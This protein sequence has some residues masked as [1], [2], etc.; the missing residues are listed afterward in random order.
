MVSRGTDFHNLSWPR[1]LICFW[2]FSPG[3]ILVGISCGHVPRFHRDHAVGWGGLGESWNEKPGWDGKCSSHCSPCHL[4]DGWS[5]ALHPSF[6][7]PPLHSLFLNSCTVAVH[8]SGLE[9]EV[10]NGKSWLQLFLTLLSTKPPF[11]TIGFFIFC[12]LNTLWHCFRLHT[13]VSA[14][15]LT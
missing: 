6:P 8:S 9:F 3:D 2:Y 4:G 15:L 12:S 5:Y 13:C 11:L 7:K 10:R 14:I 1:P